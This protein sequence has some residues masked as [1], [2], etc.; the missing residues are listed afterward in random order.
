MLGHF[1]AKEK[2]WTENVAKRH[3]NSIPKKVT[4]SKE[5][6]FKLNFKALLSC[7]NEGGKV[8][9]LVHLQS[10][11]W[12]KLEEICSQ[13]WKGKNNHE[14][15]SSQKCPID[16]FKFIQCSKKW[17]SRLFDEYFSESSDSFIRFDDQCSFVQSQK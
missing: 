15:N 7:G 16:E 9:T 10:C 3:K 6:F 2:S 12:L 11:T 8:L 5:M 4:S 17:C 14:F 13:G 1:F